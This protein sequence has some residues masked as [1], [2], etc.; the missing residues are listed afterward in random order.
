MQSHA[1]A[2]STVAFLRSFGQTWGVTIGETI[3]SSAL[4]SKLPSGFAPGHGAAAYAAIPQIAGLAEPLR[5]EVRTA[6]ADALALIF[7]VSIGIAGLALLAAFI[8][9]ELPLHEV[10]VCSPQ[11]CISTSAYTTQD[12]RYALKDGTQ[13]PLPESALTPP[14]AV[15]VSQSARVTA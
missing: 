7:Q 9:R 11:S 3:L 15:V 6:F 4:S 8:M 5:T 14:P 12:E 13:R 1:I 2:M 10:K